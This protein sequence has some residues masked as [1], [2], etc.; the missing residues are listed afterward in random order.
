MKMKR[1]LY[2]P[3]ILAMCLLA[4]CNNDDIEI[5]DTSTCNVT[6]TVN[7]TDFFSCYDFTDTKHSIENAANSSEIVSPVHFNSLNP[8]ERYLS[9]NAYYKTIPLQIETRVLFYDDKGVLLEDKECYNL[10]ANTNPVDKRLQL[11]AGKYTVIA[12]LTFFRS[13]AAA[14]WTL[15]DK[16]NLNT[17]Y[18]QSINSKGLWSIMSYTYEEVT[19]GE[20]KEVKLELTPKPVGALCYAYIQNFQNSISDYI[21]VETDHYANGFKLNPKEV[22]KFIYSEEGGVLF[23]KKPNDFFEKHY[24]TTFERDFYDFFYV[25]APQ[26]NISFN[27][28]SD[29]PMES[30]PLPSY[31]IEDGKIYM[32]YWDYNHKAKPYFGV[33]DNNH[34]Y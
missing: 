25:L 18:L 11:N 22:N 7:L 4:S 20:S 6:V 17:V 3:A 30:I 33:A 26:C 27:C 34:W 10:S 21:S 2:I 31:N 5:E 13:T 9:F 12:T 24:W 29:N 8:A 19:L 15:N 23:E 1:I 16:E 14:F 32:A 28:S